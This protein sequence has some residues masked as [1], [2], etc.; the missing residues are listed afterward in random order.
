MVLLIPKKER[1]REICAY[2]RRAGDETKM[3]GKEVNYDEN[4]SQRIRLAQ[5]RE[6]KGGNMPSRG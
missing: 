5:V 6:E 2:K 4:D 3:P 1:S